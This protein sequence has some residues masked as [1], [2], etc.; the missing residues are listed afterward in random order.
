MGE[1]EGSKMN[2]NT[3]MDSHIHIFSH[4]FMDGGIYF[5][6]RGLPRSV[7]MLAIRV[8][9]YLRTV[10][11]VPD[12]IEDVVDF[13]LKLF[14]L[15]DEAEGIREM[16][17]V[18]YSS[19]AAQ[20]ARLQKAWKELGISGGCILIPQVGEY[21]KATEAIT[22]AA[23][24]MDNVKVFAPWT[25]NYLPGVS[26]TKL[27]PA[28]QGRENIR[29]MIEDGLPMAVHCSGGGIRAPKYS[30]SEAVALNRPGWVNDALE[31]GEP[32]RICLAH[33]GGRRAFVDWA[34]NQDRP[35]FN[36][37]IDNLLRELCP[38]MSEYPECRLFVDTA[39]HEHQSREDYRTAVMRLPG[40]WRGSVLLGSDWPLHLAEYSYSQW[41]EETRAAWGEVI[42]E[43]QAAERAFFGGEA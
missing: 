13:A 5:G 25:C 32:F 27:Y 40:W 31:L 18:F 24:G 1:M 2:N 9:E 28:L 3:F 41:A 15:D 8:G 29:Q 26:G 43:V 19:P 6:E 33:A 4:E 36:F 14:R 21:R 12:E 22:A 17:R 35:G 7:V 20:L 16:I 30:E 23:A 39:F 37:P 34:L 11:V 38:G 42:D 10:D